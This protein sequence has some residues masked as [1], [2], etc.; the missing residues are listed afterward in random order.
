MKE[1]VF[2]QDSVHIEDSHDCSDRI[3]QMSIIRNIKQDYR[4]PDCVKKRSD[5]SLLNEWI[6]HNTLYNFGYEKERTGS[7]DFDAEP[8]YRCLA[9]SIIANMG[10]ILFVVAM[11]AIVS[12]VPLCSSCSSA[13]NFVVVHDTITHNVYQKDIEFIHDS[14]YQDRWHDRYIQGDTVYLKDSVMVVKYKYKDILKTDTMYEYVS[15]DV[16]YPVP[17]I[18]E[19]KVRGFF[20]WAGLLAWICAVGYC[21]YRF[22]IRKK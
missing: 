22:I 18:E 8:W 4:C 1:P 21:I 9:Y 10:M 5:T 2:Y 13:K 12:I 20:W 3:L 7:V 15:Q 16:P 11:I 19:K 14:I 17:V 6:A